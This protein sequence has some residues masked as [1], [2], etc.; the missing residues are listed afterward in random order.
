M[1]F[2]CSEP[3]VL[4]TRLKIMA[5][6]E[7]NKSHKRQSEPTITE[8][9]KI[10]TEKGNERFASSDPHTCCLCQKVLTRR[11]TLRNHLKKI[12]FRKLP[13]SER[14][15]GRIK[16]SADLAAL[17]IE[18]ESNQSGSVDDLITKGNRL[19]LMDSYVCC[20][21][22]KKFKH[23]HYLKN[24]LENFHGRSSKLYCDICPKICFTK[25]SIHDHMKKIHCEKGFVCNVC[26]YKAA[27]SNQ[28]KRHK[29]IHDAK[30]ECPIC[31]KQVTSLLN[32]K[33]AHEK[34]ESCQVCNKILVKRYMKVHMKAHAERPYKC[35]NCQDDFENSQDLRR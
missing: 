16:I 5:A 11:F 12:H 35:K 10:L 27:S 26:N 18:K 4:L 9:V 15:A 13:Y 29:R 32:H 33:R 22:Q 8:K 25:W 14:I 7:S 19:D 31:K 17:R 30:V 1:F 28:F 34:K 2:R 24:H 23:R 6:S 21:C 20:L 3:V